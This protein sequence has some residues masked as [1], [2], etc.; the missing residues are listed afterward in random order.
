MHSKYEKLRGV[1]FCLK[2]IYG[3]EDSYP[4]EA[5]CVP[6]ITTVDANPSAANWE[7][8]H[9]LK[10]ADIFPRERTETDVLN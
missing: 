1:N 8:L 4:I 3:G 2:G 9:G 10:L 6:R 7:H 5:L